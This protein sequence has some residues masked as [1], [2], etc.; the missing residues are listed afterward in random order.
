MFVPVA[1][2]FV[3][4]CVSS[5]VATGLITRPRSPANCLQDHSWRLVLMMNRPE[6]LTG[7][8]EKEDNKKYSA[9]NNSH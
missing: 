5:E 1:S 9:E 7:K 6:G 3:L 2:V 8:A 4:S